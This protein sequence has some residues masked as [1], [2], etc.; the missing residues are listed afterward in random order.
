[1][2][3]AWVE[4][5]YAC[6]SGGKTGQTSLFVVYLNSAEEKKALVELL[7]GDIGFK[8]IQKL[9]TAINVDSYCMPNKYLPKA[10]LH[11]GITWEE[12]LADYGYSQ[13]EIDE[14]MAD[15]VNFKGMEV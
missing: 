8:F 9:W 4:D 10:K 5:N 13:K 7:Y 12:I 15:L 3:A 1:V 11:S 14:V 2:D 6:K